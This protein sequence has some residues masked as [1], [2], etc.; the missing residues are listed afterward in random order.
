[1]TNVLIK[2]IE[3]YNSQQGEGILEF[4]YAIVIQKLILRRDHL[5][6]IVEALSAIS[7]HELIVF[8]R[9]EISES[10]KRNPISLVD[11]NKALKLEIGRLQARLTSE[12]TI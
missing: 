5:N 7:D 9:N 12:R 8:F 4:L 3:D 11:E 2:I 6:Q 1:M 10:L